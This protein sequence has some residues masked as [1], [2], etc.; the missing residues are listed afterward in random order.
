MKFIA[1]RDGFSKVK[2]IY[3]NIKRH[4]LYAVVFIEIF[5]ITS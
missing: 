5:A 1:W 2:D 4:N 3:Q